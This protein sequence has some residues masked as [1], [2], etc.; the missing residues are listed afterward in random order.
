MVDAG[1]GALARAIVMA[2]SIALTVL[3]FFWRL[4][5]AREKGTSR[6]VAKAARLW[7]LPTCQIATGRLKPLVRYEY[8][9]KRL[10]AAR[11]VLGLLW[12]L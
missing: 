2:L 9:P 7:A 12:G 10:P 11:G 6:L 5:D 4:G 8:T 1:L 3:L